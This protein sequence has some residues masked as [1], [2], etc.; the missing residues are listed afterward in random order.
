MNKI[1][2]QSIKINNVYLHESG[3]CVGPKEGEGPL[4]S[5]F[6]K[7]YDDLYAG[8]NGSWEKAEMQM[9]K[10]AIDICL[11]KNKTKP[12][13]IDLVVCGD[14]NNQIIIGNY[15]LR[16]YAIP[17]L[18]V[19][20]A[21][22]TSVES[23]IVGSQFIESGNFNKVLAG[24]SSHNAT[25]ERQFRYP[26]E[27]GGQKADTVT[28]TVTA[29]GIVMLSNE[30]SMIKV[31]EATIGRVYDDEMTDST[32]MGRA[33]A[34]AAF[35]TMKQHFND[36]KTTPMDYD[37]ILTGDLSQIGFSVVSKALNDKFEN[38]KNYDDCGLIIYD[39]FTQKVFSGGSGCAS[40]A[41]VTCGYIKEK[42]LS[43]EIKKVL[44]CPTGA[45][46]N[47]TTT[48]QKESI[49]SISHCFVLEVSE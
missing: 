8:T 41:V 2:K 16:N 11:E 28:T 23:I 33:M 44:I 4:A 43:G 14:L 47:Q 3:V 49:P 32:D 25:A 21:C 30:K 17:F 36:F 26:T 9:F 20:G 35:Y 12:T 37:L 48:L 7:I 22:S 10:D 1:G 6:D 15:V 5:Y 40:S 13:D 24:T 46:M 42:L 38:V 29:S 31:T 45:L 34:I 18:G 27:Y 19:F 39:Y